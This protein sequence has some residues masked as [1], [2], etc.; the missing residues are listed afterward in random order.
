VKKKQ[1]KKN[2]IK[3]E[4]IFFNDIKKKVLFLPIGKMVGKLLL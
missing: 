4:N 3:Y 1:E 2:E